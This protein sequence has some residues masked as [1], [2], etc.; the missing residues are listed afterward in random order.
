M[1]HDLDVVWSIFLQALFK[2]DSVFSVHPT[3]KEYYFK[4]API[5]SQI[6]YCGPQVS[7]RV[8]S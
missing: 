7:Q 4:R 8:N 2:V 6:A 5:L 3:A 1:S